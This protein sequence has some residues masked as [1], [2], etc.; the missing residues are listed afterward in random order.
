MTS[1]TIVPAAFTLQRERLELRFRG[2]TL[3][4]REW[5]TPGYVRVRLTGPD[6]VGFGSTGH[7]DHV[8]IF[9]PDGEPATIEELRAAPSREFTPLAWGTD[10]EGI[11]W[12]DLEFALHGDEGVAGVWAATAPLGTPAGIGGPRGSMRIEGTPHGWLLAG[13]ETAVPQ[14]RRYAA[15]I[16]EGT[17]ATIL[18]EVADAEHEIPF[19]A[20][21]AVE[22][23]HR[24]G[25][26]AGVA[27]AARL[28]AITADARPEGDVFGFVAAEQSIVKAGRALLCDRWGLDPD[29]VVVK[30]YWR[31][32]DSGYHAPH[33]PGAQG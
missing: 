33:G 26:P 32:G 21:V 20:P 18:V 7:D 16:A 15:L 8:R 4:A 31:R 5:I 28:D 9:L 19:D 22:Y 30:G 24:G 29:L 14:I 23:V 17:P 12:L 2:C 27:L 1:Q 10:G 6:L 13:D 25:A 11:G 3:T